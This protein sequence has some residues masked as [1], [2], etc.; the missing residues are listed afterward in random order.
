[1]THMTLTLQENEEIIERGLKTFIEVGNALLEIRDHEMYKEAGFKDFETY[2]KDRWNLS[3]SYVKHLIIASETVNVLQDE[4]SSVDNTALPSTERQARELATL[5]DEPKV[6]RKVWDLAV[7][8]SS[9]KTPTAAEIR[10][11]REEYVARITGYVDSYIFNMEQSI[12]IL[13]TLTKH[14]IPDAL[15]PLLQKASLEHQEA[16]SRVLGTSHDSSLRRVK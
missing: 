9:R 7:Q 16:S 13:N 15:I 4:P 5:R 1:M 3:I 6:M 10:E 11:T 12:D 14:D 8:Q 2:C